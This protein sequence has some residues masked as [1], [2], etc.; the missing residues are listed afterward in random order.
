MLTQKEL[1][2]EVWYCKRTG[3]FWSKK[4]R[5]SGAQIGEYLCRE[6]GAR[7]LG[8]RVLGI[9][10]QSHRLAWLYVKGYFPEND[11][12]HKDGVRDNNRIDNLREVSRRCNLQNCKISTAN[13]SGFKG[14]SRR[15]YK[16]EACASLDGKTIYIG[17]YSTVLEAA[18][19][20][21]EW[22]KKS[23]DWSCDIRGC[24]DTL[25]EEALAVEA[26]KQEAVLQG[27]LPWI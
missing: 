6:Y 11:I 14:V 4:D 9:K 15:G 5:M 26:A 2:E 10:Y 25:I 16:W 19:A 12:D 23:P 18:L 20:R 1:K 22:E 3:R 27:I 7:Y 24:N 8:F 17:T 21:Q 13:T